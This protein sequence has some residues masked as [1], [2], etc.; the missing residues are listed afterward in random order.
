MLGIRYL[1]DG[2]SVDVRHF[3]ECQIQ[4]LVPSSELVPNKI[5]FENQTL[6]VPLSSYFDTL[7]LDNLVDDPSLYCP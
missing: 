2:W 1:V 6:N 7:K 4:N 3:R 5:D